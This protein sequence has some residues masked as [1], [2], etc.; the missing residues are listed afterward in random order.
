MDS[1]N[2][3]TFSYE[4]SSILRDIGSA[5]SSVLDK[6][7]RKTSTHEQEKY[8]VRDYRKWLVS[9]IPKIDSISLQINFIIPKYLVPFSM[10]VNDDTKN[11]MVG[12]LYRSKTLGNR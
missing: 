8:D 12:C 7:V 3:N 5:F 1:K 11:T 9:N 6:L 4:Y 10:L 2:N